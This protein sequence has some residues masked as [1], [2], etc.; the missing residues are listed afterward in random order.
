VPRE[1]FVDARQAHEAYSDEALPIGSGQTISQPFVV[2]LMTEALH[3]VA[4]DHVLEI[5][6]G[7][8]YQAAV[9]QELGAMVTTIERIPKLAIS[10]AERLLE[11]GY[12]GIDVHIGDGSKGWP[13]GSPYDGIIVTAGAPSIPQSLLEQLADGGR[14]V[15]PIGRA[16]TQE[17]LQVSR[18]GSRFRTERLGP[19]AFVP[20]IG[21]EGWPEPHP[22]SIAPSPTAPQTH[23]PTAPPP[24]RP[25]DPQTPVIDLPE[26]S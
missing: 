1:R 26:R 12:N 7:S 16:Q 25:T 23:H 3:V 6:T 20:L 5:G 24:H 21:A 10:A 14:L 22:P 18:S 15:A 13:E 2:T 8:G 4:G 19:V 11:L 9:L 17:L